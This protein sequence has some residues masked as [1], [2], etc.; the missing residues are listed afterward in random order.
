MNRETVVRWALRVIFAVLGTLLVLGG[1][2]AYLPYSLAYNHTA[3]LPAGFY[4]SEKISFD[5]IAHGDL[6]CFKRELPS[7]AEGR[8]YGV[9]GIDLCKQVLGL[10][11]DLIERTAANRI[12]LTGAVGTWD[13]GAVLEIDS[14]GRVM[15]PA[16]HASPIPGNRLYAAMVHLPNSLD[17]RYLGLVRA[18]MVTRRIHP[19][20]TW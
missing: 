9:A 5:Q 19:L 7:W 3:S 1:A 15:V 8:H 14:R 10:P 12:Q 2:A 20:V 13:G 4:L 17:S 6:V 18:E 16:V 11:G